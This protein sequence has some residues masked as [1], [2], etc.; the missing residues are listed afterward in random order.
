MRFGI[1]KRKHLPALF[2]DNSEYALPIWKY[3]FVRQIEKAGLQLSNLGITSFVFEL[4]RNEY[5][6]PFSLEGKTVLDIGA[7]NGEVAWW[8]IHKLH[9][10]KVICIECDK[11]HLSYLRKNKDVIDNIRIIGEMVQV[12]HLKNLEYDFIKCDIE[13]YE[14]VLIDY[15]NQGFKLKPCIVE[16]HTGWIRDRFLEK[17]FTV[18]SAKEETMVGAGIYTM[19]NFNLIKNL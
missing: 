19:N 6:F 15:L 9:A 8:F 5:V 3:R 7:S 16:V 2:L 12:H 10:K 11:K 13:G 1:S 18:T 4:P 17:G 14:M